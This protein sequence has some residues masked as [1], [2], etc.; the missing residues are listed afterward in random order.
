ML[1]K[2]QTQV[3]FAFAVFLAPLT[4]PEICSVLVYFQNISLGEVCQKL[5]SYKNNF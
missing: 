2:Q 3:D 4:N 5:S 1:D